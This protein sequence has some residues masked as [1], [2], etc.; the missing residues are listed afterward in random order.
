[1]KILSFICF[2]AISLFSDT[3]ISNSV[4]TNSVIGDNS[5]IEKG[6]GKIIT[7][8]ITPKASFN[9]IKIDIAGD[10]VINHSSKNS[11]IVETDENLINKVSAYVKNGV[12]FIK[13][14]GSLNPSKRLLIKIGANSLK[15]LIVD[16]ASDISV[17]NFILDKFYLDVDGAS[18]IVVNS[19]KFNNLYINSDGSYDINLINSQAKN[20]YIKAS[21]SGDIKINVLNYLDVSIDGTT[22][23]KY[24]GNPRIKKYIDGVGELIHI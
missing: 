19:S 24:S 4:I 18:D 7:K 16:G 15:K 21:G 9:Q 20:A 6:S 23:I 13:V 8:D 5:N 10:I 17:N 12:L 22:D 14:N 1:M 2:F 3:Y 11:V